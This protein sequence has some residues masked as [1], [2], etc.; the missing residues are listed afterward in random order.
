MLV[1]ILG[2]S[3]SIAAGSNDCSAILV[4]CVRENDPKICSQNYQI[5]ENYENGLKEDPANGVLEQ[6]Q[7][8]KFRYLDSHSE[9]KSIPV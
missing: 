5:C 9:D 7:S 3:I 2:F 1:L 6:F 4:E 8:V